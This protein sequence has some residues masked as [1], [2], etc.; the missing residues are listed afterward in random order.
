MDEMFPNANLP[1]HL[2]YVH[3]FT[4]FS[5]TPDSST[6]LY[7]VSHSIRGGQR[8]ASVVPVSSIKRS[9]HLF[10][11]FGRVAPREWTSTTVLEQCKVFYLN[12][13]SD[14]HSYITMY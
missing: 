14:H 7:K 4:P 13:F 1:E 8:E 5:A 10:P 6:G 2:A 3:W 11:A 12:L 9:I